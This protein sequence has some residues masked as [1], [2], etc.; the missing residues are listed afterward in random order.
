M[1][2]VGEGPLL[3]GLRWMYNPNTIRLGEE[4]AFGNHLVRTT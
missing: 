3:F 1:E 2:K 4:D